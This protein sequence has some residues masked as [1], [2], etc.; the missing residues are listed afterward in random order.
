MVKEEEATRAEFPEWISTTSPAWDCRDGVPARGAN[1]SVGRVEIVCWQ[2]LSA[3]GEVDTGYLVA[4]DRYLH[5]DDGIDTADARQVAAD[6][7][8]A[9]DLIDAQ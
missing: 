1:L 6:L 2:E 3:S 7:I 5:L 8:R 9:A 4:A